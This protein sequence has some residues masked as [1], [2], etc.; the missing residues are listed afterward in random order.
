M[1]INSLGRALVT[2]GSAALL[3]S[4]GGG[5]GGESQSPPV[6]VTPTPPVLT[7]SP[8]PTPTPTPSP[9]YL[10]V[11]DF[12]RDLSFETPVAEVRV[13]ERYDASSP[14]YYVF[15]SA[16]GTLLHDLRAATIDY[17]AATQ[18]LTI[19]VGSES[20]SLPREALAERTADILR[21]GQTV[22]DITTAFQL[23][24][25]APTFQYVSG[26]R[27]TRFGSERIDNGPLT[28]YDIERY[29]LLG[30]PT[31]ASDVPSSGTASYSSYLTTSTVTFDGGTGLGATGTL[32]YDFAT[33]Q[34]SG[35]FAASQTGWRS[36]NTPVQATLVFSGTEQ[37]GLI[38]GRISSPDSA[39]SGEFVGRLLGP[40]GTELGLVLTITANGKS[41]AGQVT[42]KKR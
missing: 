8:T 15:D 41:A 35:T 17:R 2:V 22:S 12:S 20:T 36:E 40:A 34:L 9:T 13:T 23:V 1:R 37:N 38:R 32:S 5:G 26:N 28:R 18:S 27:M 39:Y 29:F 11:F 25:P 42:A 24:R 21:Y 6:Q 30:T 7:P 10:T 4:C 3:T 31:L 14:R 16:T 33:R 19:A